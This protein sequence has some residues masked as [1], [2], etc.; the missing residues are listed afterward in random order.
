MTNDTPNVAPADPR[1][2]GF[3]KGVG[4]DYGLINEFRLDGTLIQ[5]V[6]DRA[7]RPSHFRIE[8]DYIITS[9]EQPDGS[10]S[11]QK[12]Q[13]AISGDTLTFIYSPRKKM[14]F[15]KINEA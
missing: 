8:G 13:Y 14:H 9:L 4:G 6:G 5:H 11:E 7:S 15:Q 10:I 2:I 1:I 3:W 12:E